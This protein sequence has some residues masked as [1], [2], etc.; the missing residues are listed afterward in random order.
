MAEEYNHLPAVRREIHFTTCERGHL[1]ARL[2]GGARESWHASFRLPENGSERLPILKGTKMHGK[3]IETIHDHLGRLD[4]ILRRGADGHRLGSFFLALS[5]AR[6]L[7]D[8][9]HTLVSP[10]QTAVTG[11]GLD[12]GRYAVWLSGGE[13][14]SS[15]SAQMTFSLTASDMVGYMPKNH[16]A[17]L[18]QQIKLN[19]FEYI[20]TM[21][22]AISQWRMHQLLTLYEALAQSGKMYPVLLKG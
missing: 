14:R 6:G 4:E 3:F 20:G 22:T 7:H 18:D 16:R 2:S 17:Q 10:Y 21:A 12:S 8:Q 9:L 1:V 15:W 5:S 11:I 19:G 13:D